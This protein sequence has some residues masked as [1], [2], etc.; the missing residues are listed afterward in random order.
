[1]TSFLASCDCGWLRTYSS[2]AKAEYGLRAHSCA[3]QLR[4]A[5]AAERG[6]ARRGKVD[7]TPKPCLHKHAQHVHGTHATYVLDACRCLPCSSANSAYE[8]RRA[9]LHAYGRFNDW[10]DAA[11]V[12]THI[13]QLL[14]AG[15]GLKRIAAVSGCSHGTL[16]KLIYGGRGRPPSRRVHVRTAGRLLTVTTEQHAP[17]ARVPA[18]G[19][20]RRVQALI[21]IGYSASAIATRLGIHR[22]NF[23]YVLYGRRDIT[24][25]TRDAIAALYAELE[26]TPAVGTDPGTRCSITVARNMAARNGWPVPAA[27][28][29][30]DDPAETP[31]ADAAGADADQAPPPPTTELECFAEDVEW[32][33]DSGL[34][35]TEI[36]GRLKV[37]EAAAERRL[38]RVGRSDLWRRIRDRRS[39]ERN[40]A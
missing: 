17:G 15:V 36:T 3:K 40:V 38:R 33:A 1:M 22:S 26:H 34:T 25:R 32:L 23:T 11:P 5:A 39:P 29:D 37:T 16:S 2:Q 18:L 4:L 12:R 20:S 27:W 21:A 35:I 28:D 9:R 7:R 24:V 10:T 14:D 30:I 13:E 19:S 31:H 6:R 8:K